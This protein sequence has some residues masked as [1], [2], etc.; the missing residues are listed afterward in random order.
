[1]LRRFFEKM[2]DVAMWER[3]AF[4]FGILVLLSVFVMFAVVNKQYNGDHEIRVDTVYVTVPDSTQD[5]I[6]TYQDSLIHTLFQR[7]Q[8]VEDSMHTPNCSCR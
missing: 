5:W 6:N 2:S 4:G 8:V 1:M 3:V 7:L